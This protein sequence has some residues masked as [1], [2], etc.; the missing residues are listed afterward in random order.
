[1]ALLVWGIANGHL[2]ELRRPLQRMCTLIPR[3]GRAAANSPTYFNLDPK[4]P[5]SNGLGR[6]L[7]ISARTSRHN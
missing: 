6:T 3:R 5:P 2:D 7:A 1:M 4:M